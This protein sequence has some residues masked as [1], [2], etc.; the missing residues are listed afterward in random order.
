MT[1]LVPRPP[2]TDPEL[3]TLYPSNLHLQQV[4][5]L[6]RHGERT[7]VKAR[8]ASAGLS[9][10]WPYC[11]VARQMR[12]ALLN[13]STS[14]LTTFE[15]KRQL[16]SFGPNDTV[17]PAKAPGGQVDAICDLGM[18]TDRGR[19]TTHEL[20]TRLRTLYIDQLGFLPRTMD[21]NDFIY[22]RSTYMP[23]ALE[24]L[25]QTF[26]GLYPIQTRAPQLPLPTIISRFPSEETLFPNEWRC[27]RF[28]EL[29]AAFAQRA[30]DTWNDSDDMAYINKKIGKWMPEHSPRIAV[31]SQPRLVGIIDSIN[32]TAAHGPATKLPKEF[33]D[34]KVKQI[35]EKIV[36][37]EWFTGYKESQEYRTLG[38]GALLGDVVQR[39]VSS[40]E[41]VNS[42]F[43]IGL[44]G[45]HDTTLA[46]TIASLGAYN[47]EAW[48]PFTSHV[49]IELSR[50]A[51][52]P[53]PTPTTSSTKKSW[54]PSAISGSTSAIGRKKTPELS[55]GEK[56]KL[57]GYYVRVRYNDE[58][59]TIPGC[60]PAGNHLDGDESFCTLVCNTE[61]QN[62]T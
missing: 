50:S 51:D 26:Q 53:Q 21:S 3:S 57:H 1:T 60:K 12:S 13:P 59:V 45:C 4:Q 16:E 24:S 34:P 5:I 2:Y 62:W 30:A 31:D 18:L 55:E 17:S 23:R 9:Q 8:F 41:N 7:P 32:S 11:T 49:A 14:S 28:G 47:T 40:A 29:I 37:D 54:I 43:K 20:G 46:A 33:Y 22:L 52:Q 44:S 19:V 48:P 35:G 6:L 15:W 25:Q 58:P 42:P 36:V 27:R 61:N 10:Y 39:M 56:K 38:I